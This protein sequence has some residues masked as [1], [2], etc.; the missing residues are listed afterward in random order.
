MI[1]RFMQLAINEAFFGIKSNAGGPFG[2]VM[3]CRGKVIAKAHNRVIATNDPTA[4]AEI[5]AI[6]KASQKLGRF[7]LSDCE[8][9]STCE[10]CPMCLS[11]IYWARIPILFYGCNEDDTVEIGFADKIIHNRFKN[12]SVNTRLKRFQIERKPCM[13]LFKSWKQKPDKTPY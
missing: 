9:Y 4:H 8:I 7:D 1:N 11:A 2:A 13:E 10:P 6:R 12:S 5:L 3:A